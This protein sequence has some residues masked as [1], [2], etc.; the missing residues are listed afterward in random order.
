M[1]N[2]LM[3]PAT[4]ATETIHADPELRD[5]A[6]PV[7][8]VGQV[9][10]VGILG[11]K[12]IKL[13]EAVRYKVPFSLDPKNSDD[14]TEL[15]PW[16]H[17][18]HEAPMVERAKDIIRRIVARKKGVQPMSEIEMEFKAQRMVSHI[19]DHI[20]KDGLHI[21]SQKWLFDAVRPLQDRLGLLK[22]MANP[23]SGAQSATTAIASGLMPALPASSV[24]DFVRMLDASWIGVSFQVENRDVHSW[25]ASR[26]PYLVEFPLPNVAAGK[27]SRTD[28][29][30]RWGAGESI[31]LG[32]GFM[33][34]D[35]DQQ[36][37]QFRVVTPFLTARRTKQEVPRYVKQYILKS[38]SRIYAKEYAQLA[39]LLRNPGRTKVARLEVC[40]D[41]GIIFSKH[42]QGLAHTSCAS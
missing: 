16:P 9:V 19:K 32:L 34:V 5:L 23:Y 38:Y 40:A 29:F 33:L 3:R 39:D 25:I 4:S 42:H 26:Q 13:E 36:F 22:A 14:G 28:Q 10:A 8:S 30:S 15:M 12:N 35:L 21:Y 27:A 24:P 7:Q 17:Q 18:L 2:I 11:N 6:I 41:C 31:E 20:I 37:D 1:S